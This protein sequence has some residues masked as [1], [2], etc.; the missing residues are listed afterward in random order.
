MI[1]FLI[2]LMFRF[3]FYKLICNNGTFTAYGYS[4]INAPE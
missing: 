1:L 2:I 4:S 3:L